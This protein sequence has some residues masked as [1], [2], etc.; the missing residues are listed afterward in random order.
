[1]N[2]KISIGIRA[3]VAIISF[4][5]FLNPTILGANGYA[6]AIDGIVIGRTICLVYGLFNIVHIVETIEK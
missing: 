2:K 3:L 5:L 1:M 6:L 4:Y